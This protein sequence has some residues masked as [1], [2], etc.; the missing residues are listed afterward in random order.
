MVLA[1]RLMLAVAGLVGAAT[2][3]L[4]SRMDDSFTIPVAVAAAVTVAGAG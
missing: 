2:E 3:R 4:S 1:T